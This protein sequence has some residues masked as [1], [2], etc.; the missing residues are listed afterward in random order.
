LVSSRPFWI[1]FNTFIRMFIPSFH[2]T[3]SIVDIVLF[4]PH[5]ALTKNQNRY[6]RMMNFF[7]LFSLWRAHLKAVYDQQLLSL[8]DIWD[9]FLNSVNLHRQT[10]QYTP[11]NPFTCI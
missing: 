3:N 6:L 8:D 11:D 2:S 4:Y 7:A 1:R 9:L 5:L 10:L